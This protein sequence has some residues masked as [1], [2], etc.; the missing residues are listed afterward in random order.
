MGKGPIEVK[1]LKSKK[2]ETVSFETRVSSDKKTFVL[3]VESSCRAT[4]GEFLLAVL[5][6]SSEQFEKLEDH[7]QPQQ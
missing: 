4:Y 5:D 7:G 3:V 2:Q 6:F 1:K